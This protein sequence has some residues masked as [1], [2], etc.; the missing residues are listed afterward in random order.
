VTFGVK[1]A[2]LATLLYV[3]H[4]LKCSKLQ[5]L[6]FSIRLAHLLLRWCAMCSTHS[7]LTRTLVDKA[8]GTLGS[9]G[10]G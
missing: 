6:R 2:N 9:Q 1:Q 7:W 8:E 5:S 4:V 10:G 3:N